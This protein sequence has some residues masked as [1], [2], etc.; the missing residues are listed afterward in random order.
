MQNKEYGAHNM[1]T[2]I[3]TLLINT[4]TTM[5]KTRILLSEAENFT[6]ESDQIFVFLAIQSFNS[7]NSCI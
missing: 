5:C 2:V 6:L 7:D 4:K 1:N 3:Y